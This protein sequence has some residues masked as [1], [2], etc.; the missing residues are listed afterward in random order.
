M[1]RALY[2]RPLLGLVGVIV[3]AGVN[4]AHAAPDLQATLIELRDKLRGNKTTISQILCDP[5]YMELHVEGPFRRLIL[6]FAVHPQVRIVGPDEPGQPLHLTG[7]VRDADG[8]P[9]P[10]ALV[11]A[12]QTDARGWYGIREMDFAVP[13][14]GDKARLFGY[15][16]TGVEGQYGLQTIRPVHYPRSQHPAHI[17][18][19]ISAE[20]YETLETEV[21]FADDPRITAQERAVVEYKGWFITEIKRHADTY[22][23]EHFT[24]QQD[25]VLKRGG[26]AGR[27]RPTLQEPKRQRVAPVPGR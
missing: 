1:N 24:A 2:G 25:F 4:L 17:K 19:E 16:T 27:P 23:H 9:I 12:Y 7:V 11:F 8:K 3:L 6:D 21:R 26:T 15:M 20:G 22:I 18:L 14:Q 13:K 5:R 10:G